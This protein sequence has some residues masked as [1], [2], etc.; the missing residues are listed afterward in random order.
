LA[1]QNLMSRIGHDLIAQLVAAGEAALDI[2]IPAPSVDR[3]RKRGAPIDWVAFP[4]APASLIGIGVAS[5]PVHPNAAQLYVDFALSYDG[6]KTLADL[7][8][9]LARKEFLQQQM[10]KAKGLQMVAVSPELGEN[11][12][13]YSKLMREIFGQ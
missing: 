13:E 4:P 12:V 11:I 5:Q 3:V 6:Q 7:G 1:K 8:R 9:Y 10:S 2:D